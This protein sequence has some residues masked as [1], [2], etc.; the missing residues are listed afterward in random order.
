[1]LINKSCVCDRLALGA[2]RRETMSLNGEEGG[3]CHLSQDEESRCS[4]LVSLLL[5]PFPV[6]WCARLPP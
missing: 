1:M 4:G 6:S 3:Q 2:S 5:L